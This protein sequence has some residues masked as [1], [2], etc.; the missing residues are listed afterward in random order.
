MTLGVPEQ[1]PVVGWPRP[2]VANDYTTDVSHQHSAR[3]LT[4]GDQCRAVA[5]RGASMPPGRC[6][7]PRLCATVD[8][9]EHSVLAPWMLRT[10]AI[11]RD[12][13]HSGCGSSPTARSPWRLPLLGHPGCGEQ[14]VKP[15]TTV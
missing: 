10:A 15:A 8:L 14:Q 1:Q 13:C 9:S 6:A 5:M 11:A 7:A 12:R 3:S 4:S 2:E